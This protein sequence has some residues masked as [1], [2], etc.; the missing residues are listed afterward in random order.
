[1]ISDLGDVFK[2]RP[3][4]DLL[5]YQDLTLQ[6]LDYERQYSDYWNSTAES[7]GLLYYIGLDLRQKLTCFQA[8]LSTLSL[9]PL[10]RTL[11]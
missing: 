1:M 10:H 5:E 6:G 11:L 7:D 4:M 9:C 3:P 8:M 2:L